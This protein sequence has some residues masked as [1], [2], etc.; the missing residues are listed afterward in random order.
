LVS[1]A[2]IEAWTI[3]EIFVALEPLFVKTFI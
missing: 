2:F 1:L 3:Y